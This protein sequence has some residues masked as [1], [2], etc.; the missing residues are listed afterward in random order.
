MI[1]SILLRRLLVLGSKMGMDITK[2]WPA[3]I[4][5]DKFKE[6]SLNNYGFAAITEV[7]VANLYVILK[8]LICIFHW[9]P[10]SYIDDS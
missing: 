10:R 9:F 5:A 6:N 4:E 1:L 3:E 2:K 8:S 7:E